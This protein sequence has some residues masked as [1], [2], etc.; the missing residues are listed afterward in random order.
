[1]K[2]RREESFR[3][4]KNIGNS[5]FSAEREYVS[6]LQTLKNKKR[7]GERLSLERTGEERGDDLGQP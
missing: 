4:K 3:P 1:V 6:R 5:F 2:R 7:K